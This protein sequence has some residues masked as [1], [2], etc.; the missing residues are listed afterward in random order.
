MA[1]DFFGNLSKKNPLI[2]S[3]P[4]ESKNSNKLKNMMIFVRK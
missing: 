1:E 3:K 4:F 2:I